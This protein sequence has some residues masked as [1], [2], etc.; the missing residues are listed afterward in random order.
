MN[1]RL[2]RLLVLASALFLLRPLPAAPTDHLAPIPEATQD[3]KEVLALL[4]IGKPFIDQLGAITVP[5]YNPTKYTITGCIVRVSLPAEKIE[6]IYYSEN[7][8]V[9]PLTDGEFTIKTSLGGR[10]S[11]D[12]KVEILKLRYTGKK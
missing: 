5:F 3:E 2:A 7:A 12:L 6:R 10:R 8:G 4:Q 1:T 9:Q 11:E